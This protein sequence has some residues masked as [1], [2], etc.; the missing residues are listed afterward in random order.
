MSRLALYGLEFYSTVFQLPLILPV[1]NGVFFDGWGSL[2]NNFTSI[3]SGVTLIINSANNS[4]LI[5]TSR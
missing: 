2:R 3:F 5:V 4:L 1:T